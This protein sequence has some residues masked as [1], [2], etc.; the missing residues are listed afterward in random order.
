MQN[1]QQEKKKEG[2]GLKRQH[3]ISNTY[4]Y[5]ENFFITSVVSL[6]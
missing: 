5:I 6:L 2:T 1:F 3:K 4:D